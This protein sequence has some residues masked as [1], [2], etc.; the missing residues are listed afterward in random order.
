MNCEH[1]E[2]RRAMR[3]FIV[4][5]RCWKMFFGEAAHNIKENT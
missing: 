3:G 5:K 4:C 1:C 2:V